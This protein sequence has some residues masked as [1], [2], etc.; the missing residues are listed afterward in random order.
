MK[1]VVLFLDGIAK[2]GRRLLGLGGENAR[3]V[4]GVT[5]ATV[6]SNF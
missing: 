3:E 5:E 2:V 1:E 4:G 6:K